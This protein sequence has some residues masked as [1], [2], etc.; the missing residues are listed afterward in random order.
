MQ[1]WFHDLSPLEYPAL[2]QA[3]AAYQEAVKYIKNDAVVWSNLG[4]AYYRADRVDDA[5]TAQPR[6]VGGHHHE[7]GR[8]SR[9]GHQ[10][11]EESRED[12][13]SGRWF[14]NS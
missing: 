12:D 4:M 7:D 8:L 1:Q 11:A 14:Q 3:L 2:M 6:A 5:R 9:D 10:G 13:I